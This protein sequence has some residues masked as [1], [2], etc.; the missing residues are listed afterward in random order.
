MSTDHLHET[1]SKIKFGSPLVSPVDGV[2]CWRSWPPCCF[3]A[4]LSVNVYSTTGLFPFIELGQ[5]FPHFSPNLS[6]ESLLEYESYLKYS[7]HTRPAVYQQNQDM[8]TIS[9]LNS[10]CEHAFYLISFFFWRAYS[11]IHK[12]VFLKCELYIYVHCT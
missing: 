2:L 3:C 7:R 11:H 12:H 4:K 6:F 1:S 5:I 10:E 8:Y 9:V